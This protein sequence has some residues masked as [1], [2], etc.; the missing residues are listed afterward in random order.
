MEELL[1]ES[2][3]FED[4]L[5]ALLAVDYFVVDES[6]PRFVACAHAC[7]LSVEHAGTVRAA[8]AIGAPNSGAALL[9]LQ[10][11]ALV[12][13]AWVLYAAS[14]LHASKLV[15]P[16]SIE[17]EQQA[18]N[19]PGTNEML[20]ALA[21]KAPAGLVAPLQQFKAVSWRALNSFVHSG[22]HPL[23]RVGDGFPTVLGEQ[24]VRN[25]NGLMHFGY[26]M[27]ASLSG[28][29]AL[30]N[31]VTQ[32]YRSFASCLPMESEARQ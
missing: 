28:S 5:R 20:E 25:S 22:I 16:L 29:Q 8:F 15:S 4:A 9:R 1:A 7:L 2:E 13:A 27:L 24:I 10:F 31:E 32:S 30:M 19:L 26:R 23:K 3:T 18:K 14:D 12:R 6:N 21:R 11:E 17:A